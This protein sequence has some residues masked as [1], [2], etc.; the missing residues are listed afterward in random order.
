M[1]KKVNLARAIVKNKN[2]LGFITPFNN[3]KFAYQNDNDL[4]LDLEGIDCEVEATKVYIYKRLYAYLL[5]DSDIEDDGTG[6]DFEMAKLLL[7]EC[8]KHFIPLTSQEEK[9]CEEYWKGF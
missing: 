1:S 5:C 8:H 3:G 9:K 2:C 7:K 4:G 6:V